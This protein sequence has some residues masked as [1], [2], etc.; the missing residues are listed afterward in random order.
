VNVAPASTERYTPSPH[1]EEFRLFPSPVPTQTIFPFPLSWPVL[2]AAAA[3]GA[4]AAFS[5]AQPG[6]SGGASA[7]ARAPMERTGYL[8]KTGRKVTPMLS[9]LKTPPVPNPT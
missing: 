2:S 7:T 6:Q 4:S 3:G 8:S 5:E 9:V 1:E